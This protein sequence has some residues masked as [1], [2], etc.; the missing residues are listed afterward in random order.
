[1]RA[2]FGC[3]VLAAIAVVP[4]YVAEAVPESP[5]LLG[6]LRW[7]MIGPFRGGRTVGAVGV[8]SQPGV[9]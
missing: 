6:E 4:A 9:F 2:A 8:P 5:S 7:R 1:M 3:L